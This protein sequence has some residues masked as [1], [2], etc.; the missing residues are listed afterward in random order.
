M[1]VHTYQKQIWTQKIMH[2]PVSRKDAGM[3]T[4]KKMQ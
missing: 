1:Y 2:K 3:E 4:E